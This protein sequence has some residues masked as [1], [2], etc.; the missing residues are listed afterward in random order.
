MNNLKIKVCGMTDADNVA[1]LVA[2]QP[3]YIGFIFYPKSK[4]YAGDTIDEE[5]LA[6]IPA[7]IM[8]VGVFV[9]EPLH[10]L[11]DKFNNNMFDMVQLHGNEIP[12]YCEQLK[13][14]NIP[15]I[16][17]FGIDSHFDFSVTQNYEPYCS[18]FLFDT[19]GQSDKGGTGTHFDWTV[20]QRYAGATPFFLSGGIGPHDAEAILQLGHPALFGIDLNS[21]FEIGPGIKDIDALEAFFDQL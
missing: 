7:Y 19:G 17:V 15:V 6:T 10:S 8:K 21:Q 1:N 4:R 14:L 12:A 5:I 2:L 16:K 20:L 3:D 11:L 9:D 18:Y 13:R